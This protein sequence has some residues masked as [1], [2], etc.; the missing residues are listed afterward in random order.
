MPLGDM[1][2]AWMVARFKCQSV[3]AFLRYV[4]GRRHVKVDFVPDLGW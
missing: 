4:L 2:L 3:P 1:K